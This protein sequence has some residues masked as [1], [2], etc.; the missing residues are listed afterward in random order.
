MRI[1]LAQLLRDGRWIWKSPAPSW[2]LYPLSLPFSSTIDVFVVIQLVCL[3]VCMTIYG[4]LS[5]IA[6]GITSAHCCRVNE[7]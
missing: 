7:L 1:Q 5:G 2:L 3:F 4:S 6:I